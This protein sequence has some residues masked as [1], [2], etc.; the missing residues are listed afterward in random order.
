MT[1]NE[2]AEHIA[3]VDYEKFWRQANDEYR[4]LAISSWQDRIEAIRRAG[5]DIV[6][7]GD[8]LTDELSE[9][10]AEI[11]KLVHHLGFACGVGVTLLIASVFYVISV[12]PQ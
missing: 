6:E 11:K 4:Q 10:R 5:F 7:N 8:Q 3:M 12:W 2:L 9:A 1:D